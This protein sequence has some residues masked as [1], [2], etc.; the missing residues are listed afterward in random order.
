VACTDVPLSASRPFV[1]KRLGSFSNFANQTRGH[2]GRP[3][4]FAVAQELL[5]IRLVKGSVATRLRVLWRCAEWR[6]EYVPGEEISPRGRVVLFMGAA[7]V[8]Q[9]WPC[10]V[11]EIL[12]VSSRWRQTVVTVPTTT[13]R[14][15]PKTDRRRQQADRRAIRR[16][17]RRQGDVS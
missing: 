7:V 1:T 9:H 13:V 8:A 16:G 3:K 2:I 14:L 10:T 4:A 15:R 17:G 6:C 5:L 12:R 11:D